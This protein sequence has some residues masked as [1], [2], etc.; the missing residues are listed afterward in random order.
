MY[1]KFS[2]EVPERFKPIIP[3]CQCCKHLK[4]YRAGYGAQ[5]KQCYCE[6][7]AA[8]SVY[9]KYGL[10]GDPTFI[11]FSSKY[12]SMPTIKTSPKWCPLRPQNIGYMP[13]PPK[14]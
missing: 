10:K 8:K 6:H 12:N 7:L 1:I 9:K 2:V 13:E 4:I 3:K 14:E 5:R 11:G